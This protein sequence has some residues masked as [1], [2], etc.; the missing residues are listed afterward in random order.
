MLPF[1]YLFVN[2]KFNAL[3]SSI[4][5]SDCLNTSSIWDLNKY[6]GVNTHCICQCVSVCI[7]L[8][9]HPLIPAFRFLKPLDVHINCSQLTA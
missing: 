2:M 9:V 4:N 7:F 1:V 5:T 6:K 8:Q 3:E